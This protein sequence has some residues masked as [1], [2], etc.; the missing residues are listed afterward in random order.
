MPVIALLA[1]DG[2]CGYQLTTLTEGF[3]AAS[4]HYPQAAYELRLCAAPG[5]RGTGGPAGFGITAPHGLD[6]LAGA[7]VV[8]VPGHDGFREA[9]PSEVAGALRDA[10]GR[11]SRIVTVGTGSFTVAATGLLDGRRVTTGWAY[12]EELAHRHPRVE[13]DAGAAVVED[14]PFYSSGGTLGGMDVCLHLVNDDFGLL[15]AALT[16]RMIVLPLHQD[17][18]AAHQRIERATAAADS[19]IGPTLQWLETSLHRPL[20][21]ADIAAHAG[22]S[23]RTLNRR[24]RDHTGLTPVQYLLTARL[25][26][27]MGMLEEGVDTVEVIAAR[28][29]F[30]TAASLRHHFQRFTGTTPST[31][32]EVHHSLAATFARADP[33][34][35]PGSPV[36]PGG[37]SE[38]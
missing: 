28:T 4:R 20:T 31:Y 29:G 12:T 37:P 6:G 35:R 21:L 32:R 13:V 16:A 24:F 14:P 22:V 26:R 33:S 11:G 38:S 2:V 10:A 27:A 15:A 8:I 34:V 5:L 36:R 25:L 1:F 19:G 7:D 18:L 23:V 9:P 3:T 17:A 30:G